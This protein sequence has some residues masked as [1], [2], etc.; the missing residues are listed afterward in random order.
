MVVSGKM[1][2]KWGWFQLN[3]EEAVLEVLAPKRNCSMKRYKTLAE[4]KLEQDNVNTCYL[5]GCCWT[6]GF[7][8]DFSILVQMCKS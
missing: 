6:L 8:Y 7:A 3:V 2:S 4:F 1:F 5:V